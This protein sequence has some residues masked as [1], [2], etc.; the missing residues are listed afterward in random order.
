MSYG[1]IVLAIRNLGNCFSVLLL[2]LLCG[3]NG[4]GKQE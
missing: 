1:S 2:V 3:I 4:G